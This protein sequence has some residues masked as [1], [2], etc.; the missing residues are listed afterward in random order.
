M[1]ELVVPDI[2]EEVEAR[3]RRRASRH[4]LS[5]EEEVREILR[6]AVRD[7]DDQTVGLGSRIAARFRGIGFRE[8]ELPERSDEPVRAA[9]FEE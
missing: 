9:S 3:L 1:A 7:E 4:G 6:D 8:G 5:V 2:G